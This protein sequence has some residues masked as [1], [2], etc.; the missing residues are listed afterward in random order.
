MAWYGS[1]Q[2]SVVS[3][4]PPVPPTAKF[5]TAA[6]WWESL[7]SVPLHRIVFNPL[8]GSATEQDVLR[9][10]DHEDRICELIDGTLVEKATGFEESAI[11]VNICSVVWG[12]VR[13][14]KLGI[15]T[16]EAGMVKLS[17]RRVRIPDV[18]FV[19]KAR[20]PDGKMPTQRI[21]ELAPDLAVGIISDSNTAKEMAIKLKEYFSAG[22]RLVW[23]VD[24]RTRTVEVYESA[25]ES[26]RLTEQDM[27]GGG[28]V[29]PGFSI[30][31]AELF[32]IE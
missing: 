1:A 9:L 31:V 14:R 23:Y 15:V 28:A 13:K 2:M 11:A 6:E 8:P 24:H 21:P 22:T 32:N 18:A 5:A 4:T 16:G 26:K 29:L 19:S 25:S 12:F 10:D 7:G 20:L 17:G 3:P 27:L 30:K